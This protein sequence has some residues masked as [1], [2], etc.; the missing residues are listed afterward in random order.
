MFESALPKNATSALAILAK[1][2]ILPAK[3]YLAGGTSLA[4]QLGHRISVDFDFFTPINF[5][6]GNL[7]QKLSKIG[8]FTSENEA[9]NT[10][11]GKFENI[12]F[13]IFTYK[14]PLLS[15][16]IDFNGVSLASPKDIGAMK[17]AAIMD[18]GTKKDFIDI[19]FLGKFGLT[20]DN[21]LDLYDQKY[22]LLENH[23]YSI[24][25]S[26]GY[27][28]EANASEMPPM[29]EKVSWEEI[30]KFFKKESLRLAKKHLS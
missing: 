15:K 13:S 7:I 9:P 22:K 24:I 30:E 21:L 1:S 25:R 12:S 2:K 19:F 3:T 29:I 5:N 11:L 4:L 10:L 8:K 14:Y 28:V 20:T 16:A 26:L 27:F 18:R 23:L 17:I 6:Q